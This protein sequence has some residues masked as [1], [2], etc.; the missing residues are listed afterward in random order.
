MDTEQ[1]RT[2]LAVTES[3]SFLGAARR[4]NVTQSTVSNRIRALEHHLGQSL[5]VRGKAGAKP[6]AAG[7]R[8]HRHAA[9]MV[10]VWQQARQDA[11]MPADHRA[12]ITVGAQFSLWDAVVARW[13]GRV[14]QVHPDIAV[15]LELGANDVLMR[16]LGDGMLDMAV[17]YTPQTLAGTVSR[18]LFEETLIL[19][20]TPRPDGGMARLESLHDFVFVDWGPEFQARFAAAFPDA[21]MPGLF[22]GV[23]NLG[24]DYVL[25]YGGS[26]YFPVRL[27]APHLASG[28]LVRVADA[29]VFRRPAYLVHGAAGESEAMRAA[30]DLMYEVGKAVRQDDRMVDSGV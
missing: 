21:E 15:R 13:L 17:V 24:L 16:N 1:A 12:L 28:H 10:R 6:T 26:G 25:G 23:G 2:F 19:V 27:A 14:R 11:A 22:V 30:V 20:A 29:P 7:R 4:L 5:F 3:G 8:F 18:Q 9:A